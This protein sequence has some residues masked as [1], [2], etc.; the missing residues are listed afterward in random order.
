MAGFSHD[1]AGGNGNLVVT[2]L[3]SPNFD[4][5]SMG[6]QV[7]K[8]GSATFSNVTIY[9]GNIQGPD[10]DLDNFGL[11]FYDMYRNLVGQWQADFGIQLYV[12]GTGPNAQG[13]LVAALNSQTATDQFGNLIPVGLQIGESTSTQIQ[14]ISLPNGEGLLQFYLNNSNFTSPAV[15][16]DVDSPTLASWTFTGPQSTAVNF[17]DFVTIDWF[18]GDSSNGDSA[19]LDF[20]YVD[21]HS[22]ETSPLS[23]AYG[24]TELTGTVNAIKPGT[25]TAALN[26]AVAETWHNIVLAGW[27]TV[28]GF[29]A[30]YR[31]LPTGDVQLSGRIGATG[32]STT[33]GSLPT[34]YYQTGSSQMSCPVAVVSGGALSSTTMGARC[35]LSN[36]GSLT[37]G[38]LTIVSGTTISLDG[39]IFPVSAG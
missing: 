18:S 13:A 29:H 2:S 33:F 8:D 23:I 19:Q 30:K 9:G 28:S 27:T 17:N 31:M 24:Y 35:A 12:P 39:I 22:N 10:W 36:T 21:A 25:G 11:F 5:G 6:W 34:G 37:L 3:Q 16:S 4:P 20:Y 32:T 15:V 14:I 7:A 38:G 1:I 26:A